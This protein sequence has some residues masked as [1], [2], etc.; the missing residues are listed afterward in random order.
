MSTA[1]L[2]KAKREIESIIA[3]LEL[4]KPMHNKVKIDAISEKCS[5]AINAD[6]RMLDN[7]SEFCEDDL[8]ELEIASLISRC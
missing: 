4:N 5:K 2:I 1:K 3:N 6:M 8:S 7:V